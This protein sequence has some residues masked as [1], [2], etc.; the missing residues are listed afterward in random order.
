MEDQGPF[1]SILQPEPTP[2]PERDNTAM[3]IVGA[4]VVIGVILL[5]LVLPPIS[6]LD[7]GDGAQLSGPG[8]DGPTGPVTTEMRDELPAPPPGFE[9]VSALFDLN[10]PS[11]ID[12][13]ARLTVNLTTQVEANEVLALFTF[14]DGG[15]VRV[16]DA[17]PLPDGTSAQGEVASVPA[18]VAVMRQADGGPLV[19]HGVLPLGATLDPQSADVLTSLSPAG[20][21]PAADGSLIGATDGLPDA[22]GAD[23]VPVI[24]ATTETGI[25]AINTILASPELRDAHV[26]AIVDF[27][28]DGGYGGVVLDYRTI[29][30]GL[31]GDFV[32]LVQSLSQA[33]GQD[34]RSLGLTLPMPLREGDGW[35]TLGFDWAALSPLVDSIRIAPE[36]EQDVYYAR[37][38]EALGF[39]VSQAG[40]DK[41]LLTVSPLSRERGADGVR[42]LTLTDA[43]ALASVPATNGDGPFAT[44]DAVEALGVNLAGGS[45]LHWD[46]VARSVTFTYTGAAG[47]RT[48]WVSNLFSEAFK[49]DLAFRFGLAGVVVDDVAATADSDIWPAVR[50]YA[51]AGGMSL[52]RPN[53]QLLQPSWSADAGTFAAVDGPTV[54][55][56]APED[57]GTYTLTLVVSDGVVRVGQELEVAVE[58]S[59]S[60]APP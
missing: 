41:L 33:L 5:V 58:G 10:S 19:V 7:D 13:P 26:Q 21:G 16:G 59:A 14:G 60:A 40:A 29:D 39:L 18:N 12:Q 4:V 42:T 48:V 22:G 56:T 34:G 57:A 28:E 37:T 43:L 49:L 53:G 8:G 25:G 52:V 54:T 38:E 20:I 51:Q 50:Q 32:S 15:W 6:I 24:S 35:N 31:G 47:Q 46:E 3:L 27:A 9:A 30:S 2:P 45:G 36:I 1:D 23:V 44:S 55:W 17:Q 11:E